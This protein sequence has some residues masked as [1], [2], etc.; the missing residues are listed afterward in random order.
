MPALDQ[1]LLMVED[2]AIS[3]PA[4]F[5]RDLASLLQLPGAIGVRGLVTGR[6]QEASGMTRSLLEQITDRAGRS[7]RTALMTAETDVNGET[8][9]PRGRQ[10][11]HRAV[12]ALARPG[13]DHPQS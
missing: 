4:T 9:R 6:F 12:G 5:A 7:G 3:D 8:R 13:A 1:A 2:D 11:G 10:R